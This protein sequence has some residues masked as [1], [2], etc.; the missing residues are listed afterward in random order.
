MFDMTGRLSV[1]DLLL[2]KNKLLGAAGRIS[3]QLGF[4]DTAKDDAGATELRQSR[5]FGVEISGKPAAEALHF[6]RPEENP[7]GTFCK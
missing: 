7:R 6:Q 1:K 2:H 3:A 5:V 4:H